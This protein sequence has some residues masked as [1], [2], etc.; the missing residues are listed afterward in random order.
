MCP[1]VFLRM[2]MVRTL[3]GAERAAYEVPVN[4]VPRDLSRGYET[5]MGSF[6]L[7]GG[8]ISSYVTVSNFQLPSKGKRSIATLPLGSRCRGEVDGRW[9]H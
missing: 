4:S 5:R 2:K 7:D 3:P 6:L 9:W 1:V 8:W